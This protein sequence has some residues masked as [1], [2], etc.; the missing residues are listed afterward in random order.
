[1]GGVSAMVDGQ[2]VQM[3]L[4]E[5]QDEAENIHLRRERGLITAVQAEH[6][7]RAL[8]DGKAFARGVDEVLTF[9][10]LRRI[11]A[12]LWGRK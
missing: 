9:A 5:I 2:G 6:Q 8:V 4:H 12:K 10:P 11:W 1:V 7:I 3:K